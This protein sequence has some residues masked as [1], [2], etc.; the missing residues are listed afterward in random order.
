MKM[1]CDKITF[2][3]ASGKGSGGANKTT[4]LRFLLWILLYYVTNDFISL[5]IKLFFPKGKKENIL[6]T[7]TPSTCIISSDKA[8]G[9]CIK[10]DWKLFST[11]YWVPKCSQCLLPGNPT[12]LTQFPLQKG[13][14]VDLVLPAL[15]FVCGLG[16][17]VCSWHL[18][19]VP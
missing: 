16:N 9:V 18:F 4:G 12:G 7:L 2:W 11:A 3:I 15:P 14:H 1:I 19:P 13:H 10:I 5:S 8:R 6:S 17:G